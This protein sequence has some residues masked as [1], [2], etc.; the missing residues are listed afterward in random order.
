MLINYFHFSLLFDA[1]F[2][3]NCNYSHFSLL[4]VFLQFA[5]YFLLYFTFCLLARVYACVYVCLV[6][7]VCL[8][9]CVCC[10]FKP[11]EA[12]VDVLVYMLNF[13]SLTLRNKFNICLVFFSFHVCMYIYICI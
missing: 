9:L 2:M 4:I 3:F 7:S 13:F 6:I 12:D 1:C 11:N 10:L 5:A 8:V